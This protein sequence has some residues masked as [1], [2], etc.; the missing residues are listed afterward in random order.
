MFLFAT[1]PLDKMWDGTRLSSDK[2][3]IQSHND[4]RSIDE[5]YSIISKV[6][7]NTSCPYY[8]VMSVIMKTKK[9]KCGS[10]M[11]DT[12]FDEK[13]LKHWQRNKDFEK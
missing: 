13:S 12:L 11:S 4:V 5:R 9:K 3:P 1:V 6:D 8:L 2:S 10:C 7:A